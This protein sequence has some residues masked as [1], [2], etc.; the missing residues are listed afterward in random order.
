M[1]KGF[2]LGRFVLSPFCVP[3]G[4]GLYMII[5]PTLYHEFHET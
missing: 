3:F 1:P 4:F 5:K 2:P